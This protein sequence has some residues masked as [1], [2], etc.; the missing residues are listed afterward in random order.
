MNA[1]DEPRPGLESENLD[2]EAL[3]RN[4]EAILKRI[5]AGESSSAIVFSLRPEGERELLRRCAAPRVFDRAIVDRVLRPFRYNGPGTKEVGLFRIGPVDERNLP[6]EALVGDPIVEPVTTG[7]GLYRVRPNDR[8]DLLRSWETTESERKAI[9]SLHEELRKYWKGEGNAIEALY[10][11]SAINP[12]KALGDFERAF[13]EAEEAFDLTACA[14]LLGAYDRPDLPPR[15][16]ISIIVRRARLESRGLWAEEHYRTARFVHRPELASAL[17]RVLDLKSGGPW[18]LQLYAKGGMGKSQFLRWALAR[19]CVPSG[20]P[21][22]RLDFDVANAQALAD[23]PAK[24]ALALAEPLNRQL[25]GS[26]LEL[27]VEELR[28]NS[29]GPDPIGRLAAALPDALPPG[30]PALILL[31]TVE[32]VLLPRPDA[33]S[34]LLGELV[35]LHSRCPSIR[36]AIAGR[37]NVRDPARLG[38]K[39][40][41]PS[42]ESIDLEVPAFSETESAEYLKKNLPDLPGSFL[43]GVVRLAEGIP[44]R[45][46]LYVE[47]IAEMPIKSVA[48]LKADGNVDLTYLIRRIILRLKLKDGSRDRALALVLRYGAVPRVLTREFLTD[49]IVPN[50]AE[51]LRLDDLDE[52]LG[53]RLRLERPFEP[54]SVAVDAEALWQRLTTYAGASSWVQNA[55]TPDGLPALRLQTEVLN[56]MRRLL[57]DNPLVPELLHDA[58]HAKFRA[59]AA[60]AT[61]SASAERR[62][63]W[64]CEATYHDFQRRGADAALRWRA[65]VDARSL[66]DHPQARRAI[67][68]EVTGTAYVDDEGDPR[69]WSSDRPMIA[70]VDLAGAYARLAMANV[71]LARF[72]PPDADRLWREADTAMG[73]RDRLASRFPGVGPPSMRHIPTLAAVLARRGDLVQAI[74]TLHPLVAAEGPLVDG[75]VLANR[76]AGYRTLGDIW[77]SLPQTDQAAAASAYRSSL[78]ADAE[79]LA[80]DQFTAGEKCQVR[81]SLA[82]SE[83][84]MDRMQEALDACPP[85]GEVDP[86]LQP[87]AAK[88]GLLRLDILNW[89]GLPSEVLE[90]ASRGTPSLTLDDQNA[91]DICCAEA[92]LEL[93]DPVEVGRTLARVPT[94][95]GGMDLSSPTNLRAL[96]V[97][98]RSLAALHQ[99][100]IAIE[101]L[102]RVREGWAALARPADADRLLARIVEAR[103]FGLGET[104]GARALLRERYVKRSGVVSQAVELEMLRTEIDDVDDARSIIERGQRSV[105][106]LGPRLGPP[107]RIALVSISGLLLADRSVDQFLDSLTSALSQVTP[108]SARAAMLDPLERCPTREGAFTEE[109]AARF[110]GLFEPTQALKGRDAGLFS[111][112]VAEAFRLVGRTEDAARR[113]EDAVVRLMPEKASRFAL[114]RLAR[115]FDR[116]KYA[117][118]ALTLTE[119]HLARFLEE[120][121]DYPLLRM[122]VL[123][124]QADRALA[125]RNLQVADSAIE[126]ASAIDAESGQP[127][128]HLAKDRL[129]AC[130]STRSRLREDSDKDEPTQLRKLALDQYRSLRS[131]DS[132]T[133]S[134]G[135]LLPHA[136]MEKFAFESLEADTE[137]ET[138]PAIPEGKEVEPLPPLLPVGPALTIR[139]WSQED[140]DI[141]AEVAGSDGDGKPSSTPI[142][143][144]LEQSG[145]L[146]LLLDPRKFGRE[147]SGYRLGSRWQ[148]LREEMTRVLFG[149]EQPFFAGRPPVD[150]QIDARDPVAGR[151]PWEL[152]LAG[153]GGLAE[154]PGVRFLY[155][156][157][158]SPVH[159][160]IRRLQF[161]LKQRV[162][163]DLTID[164]LDGPPLREALK[165]FHRGAG[166]PATGTA[167]AETRAALRREL[168]PS[169]IGPVRILARSELGSSILRYL[170]RGFRLVEST[171]SSLQFEEPPSVRSSVSKSLGISDRIL[172][173]AASLQE[174]VSL[175]VHFRIKT[176]GGELVLTPTGLAEAVERDAGGG[177]KTLVV[178]D[179]PRPASLSEAIR[180]LWLRNEFASRLAACVDAPDVLATGL[181][182][183]AD[184]QA[185]RMADALV[186]DLAK[187]QPLGAIADRL[188]RLAQPGEQTLDDMLGPLSTALYCRDPAEHAP[189]VG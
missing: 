87:H 3:G 189:G 36:L 47:L 63:R 89:A 76:A 8:Q 125:V 156:P 11:A 97:I 149:K 122:T 55:V 163:P 75:P 67:A 78:A 127:R 123:L 56:P 64:V 130:R 85:P 83:L 90:T 168:N 171:G 124:D 27:L 37:Y 139:F 34:A 5:Q 45:L 44:L 70:P 99:F 173:V 186:E 18:A 28:R 68:E 95:E 132:A 24:L 115:G 40:P 49:V 155:R 58:A 159:F 93:L 42:A 150:L 121:S 165:T 174:D 138:P 180:Q 66:R 141:V 131:D 4:L 43:K 62:A 9:R 60:S 137:I 48:A 158:S 116:L 161:A 73:R 152:A 17:D 81:A 166:L 92:S 144:Q 38:D 143:R 25:A 23:Q 187:G 112:R 10:H 54:E 120:F 19:R 140:L 113:L 21:C 105:L 101:F 61:D 103:F 183:I 160:Q 57:R 13:D 188:R 39:C 147:P 35:A 167:D 51:A 20:I 164:G 107:R 181:G 96:E 148:S 175:G 46:A 50:L 153:E 108:S 88:V 33:L 119:S 2:L 146:A 14:N 109:A 98:G 59:L 74:A 134:S 80:P 32:E 102:Q 77:V 111:L 79:A 91:A 169:L 172:H 182:R 104:D 114:L 16:R 178:L 22:A 126:A 6:W 185:G 129:L 53:G 154:T 84:A 162:A 12:A 179:P 117:D 29:A 41:I 52:G 136:S 170:S 31:D 177:P 184:D 145:L 100:P 72:D 71:D 106:R 69:E 118:R 133:R 176:S 30:K 135:H 65:E 82:R 26:P 151:I 86:A 94:F 7:Q 157:A 142:R 128:W 110:L 1:S 15:P